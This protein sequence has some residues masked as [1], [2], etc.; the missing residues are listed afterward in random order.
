MARDPPSYDSGKPLSEADA[1]TMMD[2]IEARSKWLKANGKAPPYLGKHQRVILAWAKSK[3]G[4]SETELIRIWTKMERAAHKMCPSRETR[5]RLSYA[6]SASRRPKLTKGDKAL[7]NNIVGKALP[8]IP[9]EAHKRRLLSVAD[10]WIRKLYNDVIEW[11]SQRCTN[12]I[13]SRHF[14]ADDEER[15]L[16]RRL[17]YALRS[18]RRPKLTEVD[19][20][21]L[22]II[23]GILGRAPK[24]RQNGV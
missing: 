9:G 24:D 7:M 4:E 18:S 19:N 20:S 14:F 17:S 16:A 15:R 2:K 8:G 22:N 3:D 21:L 23:P 12:S 5:R 10:P 1:K 11:Q 6:L 13:P